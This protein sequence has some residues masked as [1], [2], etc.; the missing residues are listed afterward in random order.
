MIV[1]MFEKAPPLTAG[2]VL[3]LAVAGCSS[4]EATGPRGDPI[5]WE[6]VDTS[7]LEERPVFRMYDFSA[8]PGGLTIAAGTAVEW[9]NMSS[10]THS[11]SNYSTHPQAATWQ[12]ALLEPGGDFSHVFSE[13]GEYGFVCIFHQEVGYITVTPAET[14]DMDMDDDMDMGDDMDMDDMMDDD[15][16]DMPMMP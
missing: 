13:P 4:Y 11:V 14:D 10:Q 1:S 5:D 7:L 12:D 15:M 2:L 16:M 8:S 6:G 3:A 9:K